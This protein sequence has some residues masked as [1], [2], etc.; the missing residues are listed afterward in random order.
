MKP[1]FKSEDIKLERGKFFVEQEPALLGD[2]LPSILKKLKLD[3][4]SLDYQIMLS[5]AKFAEENLDKFLATKISAHRISKDR[6]L[7]LG[8]KSAVIANDL[9]FKKTDLEKKFLD[10]LDDNLPKI[11]GIVFEL[12]A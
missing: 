2:L 10:S 3:T 8:V 11:S 7:V 1:K 6:K 12:R 9:Q 5:W 4:K